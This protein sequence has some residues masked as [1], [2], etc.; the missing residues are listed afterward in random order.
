MK[1]VKKL[2]NT[3]VKQAMISLQGIKLRQI[4]QPGIAICQKLADSEIICV[5]TYE[6]V[7]WII[8]FNPKSNTYILDDYDDYFSS[9]VELTQVIHVFTD[10]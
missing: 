3:N 4:T 5:W 10:N 9:Q 1:N 2:L 8:R 7:P 6:K